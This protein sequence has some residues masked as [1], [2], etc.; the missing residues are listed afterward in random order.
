MTDRRLAGLAGALPGAS[1][2]EVAE[3]LWLA[4]FVHGAAPPLPP[5]TPVAAPRPG[6]T[7]ADAG[8]DRART[9][10]EP[11]AEMYP[12]PA[13]SPD[14]AGDDALRVG[15][16]R[17]PALPEPLRLA[18]AMRPL[19]RRAGSRHAWIVDEAATADRIA[20]EQLW[21]PVLTPRPE[22]ASNVAVV[23]DTAPSMLVWHRTVHEFKNL[24]RQL[25]AFR[26]MT[27]HTLDTTADPP[28]QLDPTGRLLILVLTDGI[29]A[30]WHDGSIHRLLHRWAA[31]NR[32][33]VLNLLPRRLWRA[34]GLRTRYE[35]ADADVPITELS[36]DGLRRWA[37]EALLPP[38][39]SPLPADVE[40]AAVIRR[41]FQVA[42]P[43]AQ[44]LAGLFSAAPLTLPVMRLIQHVM[45][46]SSAP[47]H[48]AEVFVS[49]LLV[50]RDDATGDPELAA[51]DFLPGVRDL[52]LDNADRYEVLRVL[53]EVSRFVSDRFGQP[54]D[55]PALLIDPESGAIP[56]L[57]PGTLPVARIAA[58]VLR[59]L[60]P[61]YSGLAGRLER[62][63][64]RPATPASVTTP[65]APGPLRFSAPGN[66]AVLIGDGRASVRQLAHALITRCGLTETRVL[67]NPGADRILE[68]IAAAAR[69][70]TGVLVLGY[71]GRTVRDD[72]GQLR[73]IARGGAVL[74]SLDVGAA[75][76]GAAGDLPVVLFFDNARQDTNP[77]YVP[78]TPVRRWVSLTSAGRAGFGVFDLGSDVLEHGHADFPAVI[79]LDTLFTAMGTLAG[80][81]GDYQLSRNASADLGDIIVGLNPAAND[82]N[83]DADRL[84]AARFYLD[85][86]EQERIHQRDAEA[87][88]RYEQA[89]AVLETVVDRSGE[90]AIYARLAELAEKLGRFD[91]AA[92]HYRRA[93]ALTP[94]SDEPAIDALHLRLGRAVLRSGS[95][96]E[97]TPLLRSALSEAI[98]REHLDVQA[99]ASA[100]LARIAQSRR[101]Y[102]EAEQL[103]R[104]AIRI[105]ALLD[106]PAEEAFAYL[107]LGGLFSYQR[108]P[109]DA[110]LPFR[111][112]LALFRRIGDRHSESVTLLALG[113]TD[114]DAGRTTEAEAHFRIALVLANRFDD[115]SLKINAH[116][117]LGDLLD[118]EGLSAGA[119]IHLRE[120]LRHPPS[121]HTVTAFE[122]ACRRLSR[123]LARDGRRLDAAAVLLEALVALRLDDQPWRKEL[124]SLL[125]QER[126]HT[127][128]IGYRDLAARLVPED[129]QADLERAIDAAPDPR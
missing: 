46:P 104:D 2:L 81:R 69:E 68:E 85:Q 78:L 16:P 43:A 75:I 128:P 90:A 119:E 102:P 127:L 110:E 26:T 60:G 44:R 89:V 82:F 109:S 123:R 5:E 74:S 45:L 35:R 57:G 24:L 14:Q 97:A 121:A 107:D 37:G 80:G 129:F 113:R 79:T 7:E 94:A 10:P 27:A 71:S 86:A 103:Y 106:A 39:G 32:L 99:E 20:V 42:S 15:G 64:A 76:A 3:A 53:T 36:P 18:R 25:G 120:V 41:F 98:A 65:A 125:R 48:L 84:T 66:R 126:A 28:L 33:Q 54:L 21:V 1:P 59:R 62:A 51:F 77:D 22:P 19:R 12:Q 83:S 108:R 30:G 55:F 40:P 4:Q 61:R 105:Y 38:D 92:H 11:A 6:T 13:D 118:D 29:G 100:L 23:V 95:P 9:R 115:L 116:A 117:E 124:L 17:V 87:A 49:G 70:T 67:E 93:A 101:D 111:R 56:E 52:L 122:R 34:T 73:L 50:R 96:E 88:R 31:V 91:E 114:L 58:S 8:A 63:A 72:R 47:A 112:A